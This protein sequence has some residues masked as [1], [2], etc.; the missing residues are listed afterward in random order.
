VDTGTGGVV[1]GVGEDGS[2]GVQEAAAMTNAKRG[3]PSFF[4]IVQTALPKCNVGQAQFDSA[5]C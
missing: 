3:I 2:L 5:Y 1:M 4:T